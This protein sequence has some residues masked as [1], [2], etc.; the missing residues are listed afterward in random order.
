M[1]VGEARLN[2]SQKP[3]ASSI[4]TAQGSI[5]VTFGTVLLTTDVLGARPEPIIVVVP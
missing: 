3:T 4:N 2:W 5:A 1:Y